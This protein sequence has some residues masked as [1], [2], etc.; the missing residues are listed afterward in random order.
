[1]VSFY[2][3]VLIARASSILNLAREGG[4]D[5]RGTKTSEIITLARASGVDSWVTIT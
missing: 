2:Y 5:Y 3:Q 1:M 4:T